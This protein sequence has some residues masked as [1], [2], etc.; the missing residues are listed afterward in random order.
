MLNLSEKAMLVRLSISQWTARKYD[1]KV[2]DQVAVEHNTTSDVGRYNK[3]LLALDAVKVIQKIANEA[4]SYH[5]EQ[6]LPWEDDGSR[7]L[8]AANYLHY[9]ED[10]RKYKSQFENAATDFVDKYPALIEEAKQRLNGMFNEADYPQQKNLVYKYGFSITVNPMPAAADFRVAIRED[11]VSRIQADIEARMKD[12]QETAMR[13]LWKRLYGAIE[14][15]VD[16][17]TTQVKG[18]DAVFRDSMISN[19]ADLCGLLPRLNITNDQDLE[20]MRQ[21]VETRLCKYM[22]HELRNNRFERYQA[23]KEARDILN[24]MATYMGREAKVA[25]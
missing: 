22:P 1:K 14:H 24:T 18:Q 25:A 8:P 2:S 20:N 5:Y 13:D 21:A 11:E 9:M 4:R 12:V 7:I 19:I 23:A 10:M 17:L 16:R 15:M 6:T 3:T